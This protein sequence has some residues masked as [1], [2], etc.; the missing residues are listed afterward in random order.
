[1][2]EDM[3][4]MDEF[5]SQ[6]RK[7]ERNKPQRRWMGFDELDNREAEKPHKQKRIQYDDSEA[8]YKEYLP[9]DPKRALKEARRKDKWAIKE[10]DY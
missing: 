1:M 5:S 10:W 8:D 2:L 6:K 7:S 4:E 3:F 9:R